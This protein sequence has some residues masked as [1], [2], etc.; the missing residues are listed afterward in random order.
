MK[1]ADAISATRI[2]RPDISPAGGDVVVLC[3]QA[4]TCYA[5]IPGV[6]LYDEA[7]DC[8]TYAGPLPVVGHPPCK[9][10]GKCAPFSN[11]RPGERDLAL[12]VLEAVRRWGGILEHPVGSALWPE[13]FLPRGG[14]VDFHGGRTVE[15]DQWHWGHPCHK[16]TRLHIVGPLDLDFP[17]PPEIRPPGR[18]TELR[19]LSPRQREAT[20]PLFAAALVDFARR[21]AGFGNPEYRLRKHRA[22]HFFIYQ[23]TKEQREGRGVRKFASGR[24]LYTGV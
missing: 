2:R 8:R 16:W 15:V 21:C 24:G 10:W 1:I 5:D 11:F 22:R 12:V 19:N 17:P 7:R 18:T 14:Q 20:P 9:L 13:Y 4:G 3:V 23:N 6:I